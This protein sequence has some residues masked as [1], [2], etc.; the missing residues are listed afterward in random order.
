VCVCVCVQDVYMYFQYVRVCI[1]NA[2]IVYD[3]SSIMG[4][5]RLVGSLKL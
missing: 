5:L 4:W 2:R 3:F 1:Q